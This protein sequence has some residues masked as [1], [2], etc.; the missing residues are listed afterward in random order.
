[1][2]DASVVRE[3]QRFTKRWHDRQRTRRRIQDDVLVVK[4]LEN[5]RLLR[6]VELQPPPF[7][8]LEEPPKQRAVVESAVS[9]GQIKERSHDAP[10]P[11]NWVVPKK[12][13]PSA[14]SV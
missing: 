8:I 13:Y 10:H 9:D 7:H 2:H 11:I 6:Q 4:D 1:M 12:S 3:L 14:G 5:R